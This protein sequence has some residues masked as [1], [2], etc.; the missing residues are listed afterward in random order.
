MANEEDNQPFVQMWKEAQSRFLEKTKKS[1]VRSSNPSLDDVLHTLDSRFNTEDPDNGGKKKRI[2]GLV[3]NMLKVIEILGGVAAEAATFM[4]SPA[5]LC[6]NALVFLIKIPARISEFYDGLVNLFEEVSHFLQI[7]KIYQRIEQVTKVDKELAESTHKLMIVFVDVC[8]LSIDVLG[9]SK[10]RRK[11]LVKKVLLDDDSGLQAIR[12]RFKELI[13]HQSN[14]SN[15]ITLEHVLKSE[16]E[17]AEKFRKISE[18]GTQLLANSKELQDK[19]KGIDEDVKDVKADTGF[20]VKTWTAKTNMKKAHERWENILEKLSLS[21]K[22]FDK[23]KKDFE[24]MD[25]APLP[26]TGSWIESIDVYKSWID[27]ESRIRPL[28][29]LRGPNGCGKSFLINAIWRTLKDQYGSTTGDSKRLPLAYHRFV[30]KDQK[31]SQ[32]SGISQ[33][34]R[35]VAAQVAEQSEVYRTKL[36]SHLEDKDSSYL[37]DIKLLGELL[38]TPNMGDAPD[39]AYVLL[40]DGL[41]VLC[42]EDASLL[43]RS[44]VDLKSPKVRILMTGTDERFQACL[45]SSGRSVDSVANIKVSDRNEVDIERFIKYKVEHCKPLQ[46]DAPQKIEI[47]DYIHSSLPNIADGCFNNAQIII[48]AV[49][50]AIESDS[51]V[52]DV[53]NLVSVHTLKHQNEATQKLINELNQSL[54]VQEIVQLNELLIWTIYGTRYMSASQMQA[55]LLLCTKRESVQSVEEKVSQKRDDLG[56]FFMDSQRQSEKTEVEGNG[57]P[58]ISVTITIDQVKF[59]KVQR[60][61]WDFSEKLYLDKFDFAIP[62]TGPDLSKQKITISANGTDAHLTLAKRCFGLLSDEDDEE[63]KKLWPYALENIHWHLFKLR[64]DVKKDLLTSTE[65]ADIVGELVSLLQSA[66]YVDKRLSKDFFIDTWWLE[67]PDIE[68]IQA[69]LGDPHTATLNRKELSW[70]KQVLSG[71][72]VLALKDVAVMVAR[73]WLLHSKWPAEQPFQWLDAFLDELAKEQ[74]QGQNKSNVQNNGNSDKSSVQEGVDESANPAPAEEAMSFRDS[75]KRAS[76]WTEK[77]ANITKNSWWYERIGM[78]YLSLRELNPAIEAFLFAKK[79][80]DSS[81]TLSESLA[82]A[83]DQ[84]SE[85]ALAVQEMEDLLSRHRAKK[86]MTIKEEDDFGKALV[87]T[88]KLQAELKQ[89]DLAMD[90]LQ[91]AVRLNENNF[92]SRYELLKLF[93]DTEKESEALKLLGDMEKQSD[94]DDLNKLESMFLAFS[95]RDQYFETIV[96]ATKHHDIYQVICRTLQTTLKHAEDTDAKS[97]HIDLLLWYGKILARYSTEKER[98]EHALEQWR[99]CWKLGAESKK[100]PVWYRAFSAARYI[101]N[102]HFSMMRSTGSAGISLE[103]LIEILTGLI[104]G[105]KEPIAQESLRMSLGRLHTLLGEQDVAQK[106][107]TNAMNDGLLYLSDEDSQNDFMG[108][109]TMANVFMHAGDDLNALSALSLCGP[110]ERYHENYTLGIWCDGCHKEL[111]FPDT[112]WFCKLCDD[113]AFDDECLEKLKLGTLEPFVCGANHEWL[114]GPSWNEEFKATGKEC[115][116]VGGELR[117][118]KRVGGEVIKIEEWLDVVREK[119]GIEKPKPEVEKEGN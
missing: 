45:Q 70:V 1:L 82:E 24:Q 66:D 42:P 52:E 104:D 20:L 111:R 95:E 72:P 100:W 79:H 84:N 29:F 3:T 78:T 26:F 39:L 112:I 91:E 43:F 21:Q 38:P 98:K 92:E 93:L 73:H 41:D 50:R 77:E 68:A 85:K 8:A 107:L 36:S 34:L 81:W 64:G 109:E 58:K 61:F 9:R 28:L 99:K 80:P 96:N 114:R 25:N 31:P 63:V 40:F 23:L 83:Y 13:D 94:K 89:I 47:K 75:I 74:V 60:F 115:V 110:T 12:E 103:S 116:R 33:A 117:N 90:Y 119:W 69:W 59:S 48:E 113:V 17:Q 87:K 55:A 19:L 35:S 11:Y 49:K 67:E 5:S 18:C 27:L 54:N 6:F 32:D 44:S 51:D 10:A 57:D 102:H 118:G 106:L 53:K 7:F 16:H 62:L 76:E 65:R 37:R 108:Y 56:D 105:M 15:A 101:F 86:K 4:F 46:G 97:K 22:S 2:K 30:E 14:M 71:Q 88:A